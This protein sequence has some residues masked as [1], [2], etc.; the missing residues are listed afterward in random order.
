[1][2]KTVCKAKKS[3]IVERRGK[4]SIEWHKD[5][6]PRYYCYGYIDLMTDE[7]FE[8]CKNCADHV[9]RAEEDLEKWESREIR[10]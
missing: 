7:L 10:V 3:G 6:V 5:G 9:D 4:P 8:V 1:M 2:E